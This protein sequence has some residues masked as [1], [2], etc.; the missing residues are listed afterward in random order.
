MFDKQKQKL[1]ALKSILNAVGS[2]ELWGLAK[3]LY[4]RL[5]APDSYVV[6]IGETSSGKSSIIN[7]ILKQPLLP[8]SAVPT[9][10]TITE[11]A[12]D[13]NAKSV[14]YEVLYK[15]GAKAQIDNRKEFVNL[16]C[17]PNNNMARLRVSLL[18]NGSKYVGLRLFDTPGY[19]S[20]VEEHEEVLKDFLPNA[21]IVV[22]TVG[23]KIGIQDEDYLFLRY[24]KE[25]IRPEI[26]VI[27]VINRCPD[28]IGESDV[29]V[30]EITRYASDILGYNPRINLIRQAKVVDETLPVIPDVADLWDKINDQ[31]NSVDRIGSLETAFDLYIDELFE[32][33][34][35]ELK[36]RLATSK[37]S[38]DAY[39]A[40]LKEQQ[41]TAYQLLNAI[42]E[43]IEPT[44][45]RIY[46]RLPH[47]FDEVSEK[48]ADRV[49][50]K[51]ITSSKFTKDETVNFINNFF[52]PEELRE[53]TRDVIQDYIS[54]ELTDL[55]SRVDDY[56][57]QEIIK[58]NNKVA[59][60]I[61]TA[62][63]KAGEAI[64]KKYAGK[65]ATNA[66]GRY[67]VQF[68]GQGGAGAG[69][70][71]A[72]SHLLKKAGDLVG[73]RFSRETHNALKH[74]LARFGATSMKAVGVAVAVIMELAFDLWDAN[75]WKNKAKKEVN[76]A[77]VEWKKETQQQVLADLRKLEEDN[78]QMIREIAQ[79][80]LHSFD[81]EQTVDFEIAS[82]N[83]ELADEWRQQFK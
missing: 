2:Q 66:L 49:S 57:N 72:A 75:T 10:G 71:N 36:M 69:V 29:K 39:Q 17:R 44:F 48:V 78:K 40:I 73:K 37:M 70:A 15:T 9:T 79:E 50:Q 83:S 3:F 28:R 58:F 25:L 13:K 60:Q 63:G 61:E 12:F 46:N 18:E 19:N 16:A 26:P 22:Y 81:Q 53:Y 74:Y 31:L 47:L 20:I 8:T 33:C 45:N 21:D 80:T 27:L 67:F 30:K 55:N 6:F 5:Q 68:G 56:I 64:F 1:V 4:E 7:G 23:Y 42:P 43:L 59:I 52:L 65:T 38:H 35:K 24:L 62:V 77:L 51:L 41:N 11:I 32:K 76:K 82:Q 54:V 14:K 34:D